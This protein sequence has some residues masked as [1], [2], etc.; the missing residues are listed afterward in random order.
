MP[1]KT[2]EQQELNEALVKMGAKLDIPLVA[3]NDCHYV[4]RATPP[5]TR[6]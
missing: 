2:P 3:T 4:N 1:T 6:C 5:P